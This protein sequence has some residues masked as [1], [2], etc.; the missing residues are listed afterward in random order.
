VFRLCS[1]EKIEDVLLALM[2]EPLNTNDLQARGIVGGSTAS[3]ILKRLAEHG[4]VEQV[5]VDGRPKYKLTEK[6]QKVAELLKKIH[7]IVEG[8]P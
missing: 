7:E 1:R 2:K 5:L 3:R 4:L 8:D 6:G